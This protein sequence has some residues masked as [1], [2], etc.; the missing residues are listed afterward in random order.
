MKKGHCIIVWKDSLSEMKRYASWRFENV[1]CTL[2]EQFL[3]GKLNCNN[4]FE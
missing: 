2:V 1:C 4:S 3:G